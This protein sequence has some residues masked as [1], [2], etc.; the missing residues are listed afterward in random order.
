MTKTRRIVALAGLSG[1]GK[2]TL[3]E[4]VNQRGEFTHLSAS[5]LIKEYK[6]MQGSLPTSEQLRT[7]NVQDNQTQLIK[8]FESR[9]VTVDGDI[10][11]DCHTLI[12][13]PSGL[14]IVP[15]EVFEAI[16]V[17]EMIFLSV[18]PEALSARRNGDITRQRPQ[19]SPEELQYQQQAAHAAALEISQKL[20]IP[21]SEIKHRPQ[22]ELASILYSSKSG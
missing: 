11:F 5:E 12:D 10:I 21:C 22:N 15:A 7:G 3:I 19:R 1:S 8:S 18:E 14:Q 16:G 20:N 6:R 2:T 4:H 17:T 13:T 9:S